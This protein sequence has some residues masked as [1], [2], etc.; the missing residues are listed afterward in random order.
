MAEPSHLGREMNEKIK[1]SIQEHKYAL[2]LI[3]AVIIST[4]ILFLAWQGGFC[5]IDMIKLDTDKQELARLMA[6]VSFP[7]TGVL[8][9]VLTQALKLHDDYK[10]SDR[11]AIKRK[12]KPYSYMC[13]A[14]GV[15]IIGCAITG[16]FSIQYFK[17]MVD[18]WLISAL[19]VLLLILLMFILNILYF[20]I[21]TL[22]E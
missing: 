1:K 19:Y 11:P 16:L 15:T 6:S 10:K 17:S 8:T 18:V 14:S 21:Y 5:N 13:W 12:S 22:I 3:L 7:M 4:L 20:C 2:F 9:F